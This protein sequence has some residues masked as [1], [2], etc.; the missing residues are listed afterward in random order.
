MT[1]TAPTYETPEEAAAAVRNGRPGYVLTVRNPSGR[2]VGHGAYLATTKGDALVSAR[3]A[4]VT[5]QDPERVA[6][7]DERGQRLHVPTPR[8]VGKAGAR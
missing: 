7:V 1:A 8:G 4:I 3:N 2:W 5:A 6:V